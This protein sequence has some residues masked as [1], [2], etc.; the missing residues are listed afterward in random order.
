MMQ[1]PTTHKDTQDKSRTKARA[2]RVFLLVMTLVT[3]KKFKTLGKYYVRV[4]T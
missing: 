1:Q 2:G 3:N 4:A